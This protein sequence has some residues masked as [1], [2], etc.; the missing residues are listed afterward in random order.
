MSNG[1]D[2]TNLAAECN[3]TNPMDACDNNL[4]GRRT[5]RMAGRTTTGNNNSNDS[6]SIA[7]CDSSNSAVAYNNNP[8]EQHAQQQ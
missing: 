7:T 8:G 2:C 4:M 1:V 3:N 6:K 5:I